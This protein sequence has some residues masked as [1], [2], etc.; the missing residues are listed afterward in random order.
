MFFTIA[1]H[2][3]LTLPVEGEG[4]GGV[5]ED[6]RRFCFPFEFFALRPAAAAIVAF[7]SA[8]SFTRNSVLAQMSW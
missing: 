8:T 3:S 7:L 2:P 5:R 1:N 6:L 4:T